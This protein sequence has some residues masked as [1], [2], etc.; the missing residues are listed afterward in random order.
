MLEENYKTVQTLQLQP[1]QNV[2]SDDADMA[3]EIAAL[4]E[5]ME[6][7]DIDD[8]ERDNVDMEVEDTNEGLGKSEFKKKIIGVLKQGD[9]E[10]KRSSKLTQV[11][12]MYLLSLFNEAGIHFS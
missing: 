8:E 10:G 2:I 12:F 3:A 11:H 6:N 1:S 5:I 4:G 9:F 7:L